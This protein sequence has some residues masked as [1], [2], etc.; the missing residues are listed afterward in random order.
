MTTDQRRRLGIFG[1]SVGLLVLVAVASVCVGAHAIAPTEVWRAFF[2]YAGTDDH[3]TIRGIRV[4]RT[5]IAV[6][7]GAALAVSGA[8]IQTLTRNPLAEPGVL[9]V[10]SGAGFT[11]STAAGLG[12]AGSQVPQLVLAFAGAALAGLFVYAVGR[13]S[14]LR[15][16][17]TGVAVTF[18]LGGLSLGT[19]L[20]FPEVFDQYRFWSIG[21]LA[22][23]EQ[24]PLTVPLLVIVAGLAGAV[25]LARELNSLVLGRQVAH[26][27]GVP[28]HRV[29]LGALALA[30]LLAGAATAVAGPI[31]FVG[32]IVPHLARRPAAGSVPW[33]LAYTMVLGPVLLLIADI[34]SRFL[35]PTG[36]V[37]VAV[38][39]AVLGGPMLIWIVR[40][41]GAVTL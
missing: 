21:S 3:L 30:T 26:T 15:L 25:L 1:A 28:V 39:T 18:V 20:M 13:T 34:G 32:L 5:V 14:P 36:E 23:R 33:L 31:A 6:C 41:Y 24:V 22:G 16:V 10:T 17:L 12:I 11:V 38:V 35:L 8:L 9:G 40:R 7:V 19:R 27:L 2:D 4:P 37:P 29:R